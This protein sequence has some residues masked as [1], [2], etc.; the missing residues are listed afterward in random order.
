MAATRTGKEGPLTV[1]SLERGLAVLVAVNEYS[2]ASLSRLVEMTGLPKATVVR[3][4]HT[5]RAEGYVE[6]APQMGYRPLPR[7]RQ[8]SS[9]LDR[10]SAAAQAVRRL[11]NDFA[12]VVKWP[13]EFLAR[14][15]AAMVI[16]VS[17]RNIAPIVLK[18]FEHSRFPL[19][20][21]ASGIALLAWSKPKVRE[22]IIR[23]AVAQLKIGDPAQ[24][25]KSAREEIAAALKRGYAVHDY[26]AP[27][28]G[29]RAISV[30]VFSKE[31]PIAALALIVLRDAVTPEQVDTFL[32]PRLRDVSHQIGRQ[33]T[34]FG[35]NRRSERGD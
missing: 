13:A 9:S 23:T 11:L 17:N 2:P 20:N 10:E 12:Q 7:V 29:T 6:L 32:L 33:Y 14:E 1:Q 30:P 25:V 26:D 21:S 16:E 4:L 3:V 27:I 19:L 35:G 28:E 15:G 8:L 24:L 18:R 34:S 22:D 31:E 5:L